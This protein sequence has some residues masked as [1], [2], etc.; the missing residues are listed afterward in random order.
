L[1]LTLGNN[2]NLLV[3]ATWDP[4]MGTGKNAAQISRDIIS[5]YLSGYNVTVDLRTHRD[6][7]PRAPVLGEALSK[8]NISVAAPKLSLPGDEDQKEHFIR[9]AIFHVFSST[10]TFTLVS[11]LEHNTIYIDY[12]N[13]TAYYNHTEPVGRIE[14]DEPIEAPPGASQTPKLPV[15]WSVGSV[16]Y[17]AVRKAL[18][19]Q[20]KLDA[21]AEVTVR[22]GAWKQHVWYVGKGIGA[23]I[24]L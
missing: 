21:R 20:L 18:G 12:V 11:P 19:G 1:N 13:A 17:D 22:L 7:I 15:N 10:A 4:S 2:T 23:S 5:Q 14:H 16:G 9:D 6:S 8:L 3:S 24:K